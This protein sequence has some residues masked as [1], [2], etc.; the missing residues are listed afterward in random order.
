MNLDFDFAY[1][2]CG[3]PSSRFAHT[4]F[5]EERQKLQN[6]RLT[7]E[8][9]SIVEKAQWFGKSNLLSPYHQ[10]WALT[11]EV[12]EATRIHQ[13]TLENTT[14]HSLYPL[15]HSCSETII[16]SFLDEYVN[17]L[18]ENNRPIKRTE[19]P[20]KVTDARQVIRQ[21]RSALDFDNKTSISKSI[22]FSMLERVMPF[23]WKNIPHFV[24]RQK[25]E[26][27]NIQINPQPPFDSISWS[28]FIH[29]LLF[30]HK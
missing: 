10:N 19:Y 12:Y 15:W 11:G 22:F 27:T 5:R 25:Q 1:F 9:V 21:R 4:Q 3:S 14:Q 7:S 16:S 18:S 6:F 20:Y 30:V 23:H 24:Q 8:I 28:P 17:P 13:T 2:D 29:L 26:Q